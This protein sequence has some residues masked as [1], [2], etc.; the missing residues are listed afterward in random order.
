MSKPRT[1]L[2]QQQKKW[3]ENLV[4]Y[5]I[6]I[7]E[8]CLWEEGC[9][10]SDYDKLKSSFKEVVEFGPYAVFCKR[11]DFKDDKGNKIPG[12]RMVVGLEDKHSIDCFIKYNCCELYHVVDL[13]SLMFVTQVTNLMQPNFGNLVAK[14]EGIEIGL[15]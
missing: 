3:L 10:A 4:W 8:A 6:N 13:D 15:C 11:P 5:T 7:A 12:A 14:M 2:T 9:S 1:K